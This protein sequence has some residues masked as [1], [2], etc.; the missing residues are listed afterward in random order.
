MELI[1]NLNNER[2]K[3]YID[4]IPIYYTG[5][6]EKGIKNWL[7]ITFNAK[8]DIKKIKEELKLSALLNADP[9]K[10]EI[11]FNKLV[12]KKN[13]N[14]LISNL[15]INQTSLFKNTNNLYDFYKEAKLEE[16]IYTAVE[17]KHYNFC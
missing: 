1:L 8:L 11:I 6:E 7:T 14:I 16:K 12:F 17:K 3:N 13:F 10:T 9:I 4:C 5:T 15:N 2:K